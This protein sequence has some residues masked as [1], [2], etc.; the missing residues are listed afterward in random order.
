[1]ILV[2]RVRVTGFRSIRDQSLDDLCALT[3][4]VGKNSSGKSNVLRVLNLFF[5]NEVEPGKS[6]TFQRDY[7][8]QPAQR[9]KK[10]IRIEVDFDL[11]DNFKFRS[12]LDHLRQLGDR[13]TVVRRWELDAQRRVVDAMEATVEGGAVPNA[14]DMARQ[15]LSMV[16][17][18]YIPNR[19]IPAALLRDESQALA[20][21]IF[22]RMK[23]DT[24]GAKLIEGLNAAAGRLLKDAQRSMKTAGAPLDN[25]SV[26]TASTI[27][28]MLTMSGFQATGPHGG[29]VQDEDWGAGHQ[30]F[31]LYLVLHSLDTNYGRFFG[32]RQATIWG[33]EEPES[34]LHRDLETRLAQRFREWSKDDGSKLQIIQTTHSPVF[35]MASDAGYWMAITKGETVATAKTVP[36]LTK[37]A[38]LEGV[39]G[40]VHPVLSFPWNP[41]VLVEG[42]IDAN[43]LYHAATI[44]GHDNLRFLSVPG[45]DRTYTR[46][47]KDSIVTY[48]KRHADLIENRP[49]E[50]PFIVLLDWDISKQELKNAQNAYGRH[51]DERVLRMDQ[52]HSESLLGKDFKG[53]ERFYPPQVMLDA[54][55]ADELALAIKPGKPYSIAKSQLEAA[56]SRLCKRVLLVDDPV[57]LKP[58]ISVVRDIQDA[59]YADRPVQKRLFSGLEDA[60]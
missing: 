28:E 41:V 37:A 35:T 38:E 46:G 53:I 27:G 10:R 5:N 56:K 34:G 2:R 42:E 6:V 8:E 17:Y 30:A 36:E 11:P 57:Q 29:L 18:R 12:Q 48:L 59:V 25:A 44:S 54:D 13:F 47:G 1:M 9:K 31:F 14:A 55:H 52:K 15:F 43:V 45:L 51:G 50:A 7:F 24:H 22:M 23:G 4:L 21:S 32:W 19:S 26:A 49:R 58:L 16:S 33:V 20:D 40:W 3:A 39:S 60:G